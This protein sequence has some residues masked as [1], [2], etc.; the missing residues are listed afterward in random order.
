[1]LSWYTGI[2]VYWYTPFWYI[3]RLVDDFGN[4]NL[5]LVL[6]PRIVELN[7]QIS[8]FCDKNLIRTVC[9]AKTRPIVLRSEIKVYRLF[10]SFNQLQS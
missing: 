3:L 8:K 4:C 6:K 9:V 5:F 1:M 10:Y 7:V 2:L